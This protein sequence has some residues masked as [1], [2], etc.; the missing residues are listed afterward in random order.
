MKAVFIRRY[1]GP[2]V[3]EYGEIPAPTP[4]PGEALIAVHAAS[5]NPIDWKLRKG[6]VKGNYDPPMPH[7]M[8]RDFSGAIVAL[9]PDV[10]NFAV[11]EEVFGVA[12]A[13]RD[14]PQAEY[15]AIDCARIARKPKNTNHVGAAAVALAGLSALMPLKAAGDVQA[16]QKILVHAG[17]GGVGG[18]AVQYARHKGATVV[19]TCSAENAD[20]VKRL[21]ASRTIDYRREDFTRETADFDLVF[22]LMGAEVHQRSFAVLKPGGTLAY[23]VAAPIPS[24]PARADVKVVTARVQPTP[25]L[26]AEIAALIDSGAVKPQVEKVVALAEAAA[27][28]A[29]SETGHAR[30]KTVFEIR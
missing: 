18:F 17:A 7:V 25:A 16:G 24:A 9:A 27:A 11:G 21:G 6:L 8:G 2:E 26:L 30:G 28:H 4:G 15:I 12:D 23:L 13:M 22:D 19:A 29:A 1:G 14:G 10:K 5:L 3:L 20:Y